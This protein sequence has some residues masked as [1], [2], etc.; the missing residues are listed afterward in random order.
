MAYTAIFLRV[1]QSKES[2]P[3]PISNSDEL[4][5][6][7]VGIGNWYVKLSSI[8]PAGATTSVAS[9]PSGESLFSR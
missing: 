5:G 9:G 7:G 8:P 1:K 6:S 3:M 4:L 2:I